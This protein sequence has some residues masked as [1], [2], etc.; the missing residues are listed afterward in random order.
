[1]KNRIWIPIVTVILAAAVLLAASV[2][3]A[4]L[5]EKN[6]QAE[7]DAMLAT[8]LPGG[9]SFAAET[10]AGDDANI[11]GIYKGENGFVIHAATSGYA[12]EIS[13]LVGVSNDGTV[14][15]LVVRQMDETWGLGRR[16]LT[17]HEF[18]AQFLNTSGEAQVGSNVDALTGATV[19][20]KA[21]ARCVNSAV[22]F[23]TGADVS[24]GAT[25]WGG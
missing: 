5:R 4:P 22:A 8:V 6:T 18:L 13:M 2:G 3:L 25:S 14:T 7:L 20:S 10:Y 12:G 21:V 16:A 9:T 1:M 17:D 19:T 15:G 11:Q 24:S 23:I